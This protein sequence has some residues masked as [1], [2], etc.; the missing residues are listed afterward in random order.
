MSAGQFQS[1]VVAL[2]ERSIS[3]TGTGTTGDGVNVSDPVQATGTGSITIVGTS[4]GTFFANRGVRVGD[5]VF[6]VDG[7]ISIT[8]TQTSETGGPGVF[9]N[10]DIKQPMVMG[11]AY[12][13]VDTPPEANQGKSK[14]KQRQNR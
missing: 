2:T 13:E 8:G 12:N 4:S 6:T 3:L 5:D 1:R 10:G 14:R 9:V 11:G 7:T